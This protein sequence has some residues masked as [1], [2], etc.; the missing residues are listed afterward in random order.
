MKLLTMNVIRASHRIRHCGQGS[1]R[2]GGLDLACAS[3]RIYFSI[4]T[5]ALR[6]DGPPRWPTSVLDAH[7][8]RRDHGPSA[9]ADPRV[10]GRAWKQADARANLFGLDMKASTEVLGATGCST[11]VN[12]G[13]TTLRR[14]YALSFYLSIRIFRSPLR[15]DFRAVKIHQQRSETTRGLNSTLHR[16]RRL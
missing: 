7:H 9:R 8:G 4:L 5:L 2:C 1:S 3:A 12:G 16:W 11:P 15:D 13:L 6:P 10:L 14:A